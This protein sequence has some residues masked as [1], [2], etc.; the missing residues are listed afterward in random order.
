MYNDCKDEVP[1]W[2]SAQKMS[3][4]RYKHYDYDVILS[5]WTRRR[6]RTMVC[7]YIQL[8]IMLT[9][10]HIAKPPPHAPSTIPTNTER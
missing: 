9:S 6:K 2:M 5:C 3:K 1:T 10:Y 8:M 7:T 4:S